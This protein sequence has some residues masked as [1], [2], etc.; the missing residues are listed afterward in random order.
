MR[1]AILASGRGSNFQSI[2]DA[3]KENKLPN[4]KIELLIVNKKDAY[5]VERAKR[6]NIAYRII[7]SKDKKREDFDQ[8]MIGTRLFSPHNLRHGFKISGTKKNQKM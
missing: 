7:E 5:A 2:I 4:C 3:S 6:H 8:Q 1:V